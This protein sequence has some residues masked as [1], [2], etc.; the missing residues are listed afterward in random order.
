M[1]TSNC[2]AARE[3][4]DKLLALITASWSTQALAA[5]VQ[6]GVAER[7]HVEAQSCEELA[8]ACSCPSTPLRRLLRALV[9]LEVAI[10]TVP[11]CYAAGPLAAHLRRDSEDSLAPWA[12]YAATASWSSWGRLTDCVRTGS[13]ARE[14]EGGRAGLSHLDVDP[15]SADLFNRAM[16]ALSA[17][18]ARRLAIELPIGESHTV[19]DI[20]GGG[21]QVLLALLQQHAHLQGVVFDRPHARALA[22]AAIARAALAMRCRFL[23]G[24][25]FHSIPAGANLYLLKSVLHDWDDAHALAILRRCREAMGPGARLALVERLMP[26]RILPSA[27]HRALARSDLNMLVGPGGQERSL[28]E[29]ADLLSQAQLQATEPMEL[30]EGYALVIAS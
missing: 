16:A 21:G 5:A 3:S 30:V 14:L 11:G 13:T 22:T 12:E 4:R 7:L 19:V 10:E 15:A 25:F 1:S 18:V 17:V 26:V 28:A 29:Y 23:A 8:R 6:L 9:T 27:A 20:A 2:D 24:D